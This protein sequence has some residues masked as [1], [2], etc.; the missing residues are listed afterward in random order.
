MQ[1]HSDGPCYETNDLNRTPRLANALAAHIRDATISVFRARLAAGDFEHNWTASAL[2][3]E[4]D[5]LSAE[6]TR[7][8]KLIAAE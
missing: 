7:L 2:G 4:L 5:R 8:R 1:M 6:V 3:K